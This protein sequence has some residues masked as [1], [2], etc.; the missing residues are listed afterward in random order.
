MNRMRI[1]MLCLLLTC[2]ASC[3]RSTLPA[4]DDS[5]HAGRD[6]VCVVSS[7]AHTWPESIDVDSEGN[8][9]F[10]DMC[11]KALYRLARLKEKDE[12][13]AFREEKLLKGLAHISGVSIDRNKEKEALYCGAKVPGDKGFSILG[14]PLSL[15]EP[16]AV[17]IDMADP[18]NFA[19]AAP[20]ERRYGQGK[21]EK[22]NGVAFDAANN[23]IYYT[24]AN[25]LSFSG[26][27]VGKINLDPKVTTAQIPMTTPNGIDLYKDAQTN[28]SQ[29]L[30]TRTGLPLLRQGGASLDPM[31]K[32]TI[33]AGLSKY[34]PDGVYCMKNGDALVAGFS[35]GNILYLQRKKGS[36][37]YYEAVPVPLCRSLGHPTDLVMA[38]SSTGTDQS[39]YV[40][41]TNP[42]RLFL[43]KDQ[44]G[45]R[46]LEIPHIEKRLAGIRREPVGTVQKEQAPDPSMLAEAA[47]YRNAIGAFRDLRRKLE[48]KDPVFSR[49]GLYGPLLFAHRGGV[50]ETPESTVRGFRY[51]LDVA[52]ADVLELDVQITRDGRFV[53]WHGPGLENVL[54]ETENSDTEKQPSQRLYIHEFDWRELDGRAWV[55]DPGFTDL[56]A[57]PKESDRQLLLLA[58]FLQRFPSAPLNIEMKQTFKKPLGGRKGLA[59]NVAAF[60]KILM[61]DNSPRTMVVASADQ[62]ILTAFRDIDKDRFPTNLSPWEQIKLKFSRPSL[63]HRVLETSYAKFLSGS[64]MV[65]KVRGQQGATYVF[66]TEFGPI[67]SLDRCLEDGPIFEILDRGVDGIMT[68]RPRA[69]REVMHRWLIE[70]EARRPKGGAE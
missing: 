28:G 38:P 59:E 56:S 24:V 61:D 17:T 20:P 49:E 44:R 42:W 34:H 29:L 9:Y 53:V 2:A 55:A 60:R 65:E 5:Y 54:I 48:R 43:P 1:A 3:C 36:T 19:E 68:D 51:A 32:E 23:D 64:G 35:S 39:L 7:Q 70:K 25:Y 16:E 22:P 30:V 10:S 18:K 4:F 45:G 67:G 27:H 26:G 6:D 8:L 50:M 46:V 14:L 62:E 37:V 57:V 13:A 33:L 47:E 21:I 63:K 11:E 66:I 40:T 12:G 31:G 58:D 52:G 41:S 69:V 15:W